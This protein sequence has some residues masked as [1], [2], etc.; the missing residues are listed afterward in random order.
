MLKAA[1]QQQHPPPATHSSVSQKVIKKPDWRPYQE[2]K[3]QRE[4]QVSAHLD[5]KLRPLLLDPRNQQHDA[6]VG[7]LTLPWRCLPIMPAQQWLFL[8]P[9]VPGGISCHPERYLQ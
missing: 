7:F 5:R 2:E 4:C 1:L 9:S 3:R 6:K 8:S